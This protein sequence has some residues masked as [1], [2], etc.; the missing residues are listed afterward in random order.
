MTRWP[1]SDP[2]G[3][4][5]YN[6]DARTQLEDVLRAVVEIS[7]RYDDAAVELLEGYRRQVRAGNTFAARLLPKYDDLARVLEPHVTPE[8]DV[9]D[10]I[11]ELLELAGDSSDDAYND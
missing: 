1:N 7:D 4:Q 5:P 8:L 11:Y 9:E 10:L 3:V 2:S 6:D